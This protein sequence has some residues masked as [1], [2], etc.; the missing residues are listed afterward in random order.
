MVSRTL[1]VWSVEVLLLLLLLLLAAA[2]ACA[3]TMPSWCGRVC[4]T[5]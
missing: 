2:P 1:A 4:V 5:K 3:A